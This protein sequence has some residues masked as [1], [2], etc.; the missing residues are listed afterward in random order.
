MEGKKNESKSVETGSQTTGK[1]PNMQD[2][3]GAM[4]NEGQPKDEGA[5][6]GVDGRVSDGGLGHE[7]QT[8]L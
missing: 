3:E 7:G 5:K 4:D 2:N 8:E 1:G 6:T